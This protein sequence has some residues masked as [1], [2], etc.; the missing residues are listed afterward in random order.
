MELKD[1][2]Y[3]IESIDEKGKSLKDVTPVF[4][5]GFVFKE[6]I[7]TIAKITKKLKASII[8]SPESKGFIL[9]AGTAAKLGFGIVPVRNPKNL[10]REFVKASYTT[11]QGEVKEL[12]C[13]TNCFGTGARVVIIDDKLSTG[14]TAL[15]AAKLVEKLGG[16]VVGII[17]L[18][19]VTNLKGRA[20]LAGYD[21]YTLVQDEAAR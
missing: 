16:K 19:E 10:S 1:Y 13:H 5:N 9:G 6:A 3:N 11:E 15:T 4:E 21:V 8:V 14:N 20:K 7:S 2:I 12:A 18:L 17:T